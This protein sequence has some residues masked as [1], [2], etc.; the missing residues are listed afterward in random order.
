VAGKVSAGGKQSFF[1][2][3]VHGYDCL[4]SAF[5]FASAEAIYSQDGAR[6]ACQGLPASRVKS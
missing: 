1:V 2:A 3:L 6:Q 5:L 4:G